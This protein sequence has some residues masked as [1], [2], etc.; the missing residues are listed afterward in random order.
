MNKSD[1]TR[2]L[3]ADRAQVGRWLRGRNIPG[4]LWRR[5]IARVLRRRVDEIDWEAP[6]R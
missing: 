4:R 2:A 6:R 5:E 1:F 3:E